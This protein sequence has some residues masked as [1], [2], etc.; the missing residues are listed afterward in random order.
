MSYMSSCISVIYSIMILVGSA[1]CYA[2]CKNGY[3]Q[4]D[5]E[6]IPCAYRENSNEHIYNMLCG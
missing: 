2:D 1:S 4:R 3:E 6:C 5:G